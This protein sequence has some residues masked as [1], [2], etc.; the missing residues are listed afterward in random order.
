MALAPGASRHPP[1]MKRADAE[2]D[3]TGRHGSFRFSAVQ[4]LI[5]SVSG[6]SAA[7]AE[8]QEPLAADLFHPGHVPAAGTPRK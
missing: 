8:Q 3:L 7:A 5:R 1:G 4:S 6:R 2:Q